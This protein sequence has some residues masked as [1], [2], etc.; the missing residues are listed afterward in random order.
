MDTRKSGET[1][2]FLPFLEEA[3]EL[4]WLR[5]LVA[6][7]GSVET[8]ARSLVGQVTCSRRNGEGNSERRHRLTVCL[9]REQTIFSNVFAIG[10]R[11]LQELSSLDGTQA[12][13][14]TSSSGLDRVSSWK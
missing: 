3:V 8:R 7:T 2:I 12:A 11:E 14:F 5:V 4:S 13:N 9:G 1:V 10:I 6:I